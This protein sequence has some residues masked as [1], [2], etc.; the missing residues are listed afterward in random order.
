[1]TLRNPVTG[2]EEPYFP[3]NK[4]FNRSLTG[5]MAILIMVGVAGIDLDVKI[6]LVHVKVLTWRSN[7]RVVVQIVVVLMFLMAIILYR[8]ILQIVI[9]KSS[10]TFFSSSVSRG[11]RQSGDS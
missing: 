2:Q 3:E 8:T 10:N 11:T 6:Y 7:L 4:R 9:Y 1:M 5:C